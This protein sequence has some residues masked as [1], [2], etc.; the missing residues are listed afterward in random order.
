VDFLVCALYDSSEIIASVGH[1][2]NQDSTLNSEGNLPC[3]KAS[4]WVLLY[5]RPQQ[6]FLT[7]WLQLKQVMLLANG[8]NEVLKGWTC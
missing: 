8:G 3:T 6:R 1:G 5:V 2:F 7:C 4:L